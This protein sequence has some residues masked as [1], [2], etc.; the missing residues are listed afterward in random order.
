MKKVCVITAAR[1]EYGL[2]RWIIDAIQNDPDFQLQLVV[3]GSHLSVEQGLTYH[4][5]EDDGYHIDEKI[6]MILSS[7]TSVGI[8][9]SMGICSIGISDCFNRLKPD[10]IVVLGDRYEL[11]PICNVALVMNIPIAH[12]SGGDVT[13]GAIDDQV[14][15][16]VT[17]LSTLH[18]AGVE[19][20]ADRIVRM[21]GSR[22][23]VWTCG[24][25]GLD[26]FRRLSLW[27]RSK[28]AK[29]L[30]IDETKKWLMVSYH[31]ETK[32]SLERNM[33]TIAWLQEALD[34]IDNVEIIIT[35]ANADLGG[36]QINQYWENL[37]KKNGK[38]YKLFD[39][40]GQ[41]RYLSLMKE[42]VCI[43]GNSSSGIVEAPFI[44]I[45]AI[46]I[47]CRQKGRHLCK[48]VISVNNEDDNIYEILNKLL[49][50]KHT[51]LTD[52]YY[53]DGHTSEQIKCKIK[54]FLC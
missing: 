46:N 10:I 39:S 18:F 22:Q 28:L 34:K 1:S 52:K 12:I 51:D 14:R 45:P 27:D 24:E 54:E 37:V 36:I 26:N 42:T 40:L 13:E 4:Q 19:E 50:D 41:L 48:N 6:E 32:I 16:T 17:M 21:R 9:K 2:L 5:I 44:G 35:R 33:I 30:Q 25:P 15:N 11:L 43:I 8:A 20:S 7:E 49:H 3:T 38:K 31:P 47:G 23:N 29:D 53:G